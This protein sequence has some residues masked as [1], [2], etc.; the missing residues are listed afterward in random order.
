MG[1]SEGLALVVTVNDGDAL[2]V[3]GRVEGK[4]D[5][6]SFGLAEGRLLV[7]PSVGVSLGAIGDTL[8]V[9]WLLVEGSTDNVGLED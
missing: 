3:D 6:P 8:V 7:E 1:V 5:T 4:S 9:G 2:R